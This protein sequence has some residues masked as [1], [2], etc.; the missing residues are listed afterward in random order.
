MWERVLEIPFLK[1]SAYDSAVGKMK[2]YNDERVADP[3]TG[4]KPAAFTDSQMKRAGI[5]AALS[6]ASSSMKQSV[7]DS[8]YKGLTGQEK[9]RAVSDGGTLSFGQKHI[10]KLIY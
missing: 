5:S 10:I 8:L 2:D 7:G 3:N 4:F 6:A 9:K 1:K